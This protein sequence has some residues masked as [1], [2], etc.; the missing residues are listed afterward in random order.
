[1]D[2][3]DRPMG[4]RDEIAML[5]YANEGLQAEIARLRAA[6]EV[7]EKVMSTWLAHGL[8]PQE[9]YTKMRTARDGL[10]KALANEQLATKQTVASESDTT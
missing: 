1:M 5:N 6:I 4:H 7:A 8:G 10:R 2:E 3:C 9:Q